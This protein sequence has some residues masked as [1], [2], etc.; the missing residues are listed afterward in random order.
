MKYKIGDIVHIK[1]NNEISRLNL[2]FGILDDPE[3]KIYNN[4]AKIKSIHKG[5]YR[6]DLDRE[7][8]NWY[9]EEIDDIK[10]IRKKKLKKLNLIQK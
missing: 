5:Y 4:Y 7:M 6:I 8:Y 9:E 3:K 1:T 2:G 10:E